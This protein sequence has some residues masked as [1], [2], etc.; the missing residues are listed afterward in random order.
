MCIIV[1]ESCAKERQKL[2]DCLKKVGPSSPLARPS[3][4]ACVPSV[5]CVSY[6]PRNS[7]ALA[8]PLFVHDIVYSLAAKASTY[9]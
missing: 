4:S 9:R 3:V 5:R 2:R 8:V 1:R 6:G 7:S